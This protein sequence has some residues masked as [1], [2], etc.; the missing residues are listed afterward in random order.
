MPAS[1]PPP[2]KNTGNLVVAV[3]AIRRTVTATWQRRPRTKASEV[4]AG[5]L[6]SAR[7]WRR[8]AQHGGLRYR[9]RQV[10][11][12]LSIDP[13]RRPIQAAHLCRLKR[14]VRPNIGPV[15]HAGIENPAFSV[16]ARPGG[17]IWWPGV[18][19]PVIVVVSFT[20][21]TWRSG[22]KSFREYHSSFRAEI[23]PNLAHPWKHPVCDDLPSFL[24]G[25]MFDKQRAEPARLIVQ[26]GPVIQVSGRAVLLVAQRVKWLGRAVRADKALAVGNRLEKRRLAG[27]GHRRVSV[28]LHRTVL[29]QREVAS[30]GKRTRRTA[31]DS[32]A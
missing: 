9:A 25:V 15:A 8:P 14:R 10:G 12:N 13:V 4:A 21:S 1:R 5:L 23:S 20:S 24:R 30:R 2:M 32:P 6:T 3:R 29:G 28:A 18:G 11:R 7:S 27:C 17:R 31:R 22:A 19:R 26:L 16:L